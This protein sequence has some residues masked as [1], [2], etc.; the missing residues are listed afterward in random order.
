M[1]GN[2]I[3]DVP[4]GNNTSD[5]VRRDESGEKSRRKLIDSR[6]KLAR[7]K[8]FA[9]K[10]REVAVPSVGESTISEASLLLAESLR[11]NARP[12][13]VGG[14]VVARNDRISAGR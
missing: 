12:F 14:Q 6:R 4:K 9:R 7:R 13:E 1:F 10:F 5:E 8:L 3:A 11:E 2:N